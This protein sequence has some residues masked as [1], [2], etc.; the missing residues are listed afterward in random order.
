VAFRY[1]VVTSTR[2]GARR[3]HRYASEDEIVPGSVV[4]LGGCHWLMEL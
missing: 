4:V 1:E 3:L 2:S